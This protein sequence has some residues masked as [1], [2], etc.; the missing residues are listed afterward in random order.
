MFVNAI[1]YT[2]RKNIITKNMY[3]FDNKYIYGL[4]HGK[5][6]Y[7]CLMLRKISKNIAVLVSSSKDG[8]II[9]TALQKLGYGLVRGSSNKDSV[10]SLVFMIKSL[11][12]GKSGGFTV[13]GP[14]GPIYE[15]KQGI[16]YC[17]Q[18]TGTL[19]V[20]CGA[21]C[22]SKWV[23]KKAWDKFEV[24]K[25]FSKITYILGE[26]ISIPKDGDINEW[27]EILGEKIKELEKEAEEVAKK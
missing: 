27:C 12:D 17:A 8:E 25:P 21:Y 7:N 16:I 4:W 24:P 3:D 23:I 5:L 14:K 1:Y 20:P 6:L 10:R 15:V 26:P 18:K 13:D 19:I 2:L 11:R 9:A 22:S